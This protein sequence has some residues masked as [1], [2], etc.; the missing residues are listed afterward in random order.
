VKITEGEAGE[1]LARAVGARR[2]ILPEIAR[3]DSSRRLW[4]L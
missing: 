1:T 4:S 3:R 2:R